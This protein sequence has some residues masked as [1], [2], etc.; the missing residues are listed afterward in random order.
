MFVMVSIK[1][2]CALATLLLGSLS[3]LAKHGKDGED[4]DDDEND[5]VTSSTSATFTSSIPL[6]TTSTTSVG[7]YITTSPPPILQFFPPENTTACQTLTLRW[8]SPSTLN[9]PLTLLVTNDHA[10]LTSTPASA[11]QPTPTLL[12]HTLAT[13]VPASAAALAW[14]PVDVPPGT[15][16]AVAFETARMLGISARSAPFV[17]RAGQ[18]VSCLATAARPPIV[19]PSTA[20]PTSAS[21]VPGNTATATVSQTSGQTDSPGTK[22]PSLAVVGGT[23]AGVSVAAA[24]MLLVLAFTLPLRRFR[25]GGSGPPRRHRNSRPGAPYYLF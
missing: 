14:R 7:T 21:D 25:I 3:S 13:D 19:G 22:G 16:V 8:E 9:V 20:F 23:V 18:D 5:E 24:A 12:V 2:V 4:D 17:V 10:A 15:Y 6:S 11:A 1:T